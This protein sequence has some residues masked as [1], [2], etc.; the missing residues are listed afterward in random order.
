MRTVFA[1]IILALSAGAAAPALAGPC[2]APGETVYALTG[3]PAFVDGE[4][5]LG[6]SAY[7]CG[8][9]WSAANLMEKAAQ[10][11]ASSL[12]RFN[13]AATYARTGRYDQAETLYQSVI[14]DGDFIRARSDTS[15]VRPGEI[16][17]GFGLAE[18]ARR[19]LAALRS[20]RTMFDLPA[21]TGTASVAGPA[22]PLVADQSGANAVALE[23]AAL[24]V[25]VDAAAVEAIAGA[26]G[27]S[28]VEALQRDGLIQP[29]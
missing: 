6:R 8:R 13:L 18:E 20:L 7:S 19:R 5:V 23:S 16:E 22:G 15:Y 2:D 3:P 25:A 10:E 26:A 12:Q 4:R 21:A 27:I 1:G 11:R 29:D 9:Y 28:D 17:Q 24:P 14:S